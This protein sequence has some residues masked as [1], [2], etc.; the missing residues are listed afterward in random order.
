MIQLVK[1]QH[2]LD[3]DNLN[4]E[5]SNINSAGGTKRFLQRIEE[6]IGLRKAKYVHKPSFMKNTFKPE[7][8]KRFRESG[9]K[10]PSNY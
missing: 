6:D 1:D 5:S 10:P 3:T 8:L 9:G 7:T 4:L 2:D